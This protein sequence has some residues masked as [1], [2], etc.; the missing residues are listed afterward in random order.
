MDPS[1]LKPIEW[2]SKE[3]PPG[4][5]LRGKISGVNPKQTELDSSFN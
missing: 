5:L 2:F 3:Q 4:N 1:A